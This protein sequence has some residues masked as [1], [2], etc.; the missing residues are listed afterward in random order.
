MAGP[1]PVRFGIL[2]TANI[3]GRLVAA[4]ANS[5]AAELVAVSSRDADTLAAYCQ[6]HQLADTVHRH[7]SYE[8]LLADE[9][10]E[11]IYNPL[12]NSL[13]AEWTIR[14]AAAGKHI[15]CEK[16]LA[17]DVSECQAMLAAADQ[18]GVRFMEAFMY[19]YHP[20]TQRVRELVADGAIGEVRLIRSSFCFTIADPANIRVRRD[21]AGGATMDV[22]CY[23][24][25]F[26]RLI[27][28]AE[29][30]R[31]WATATFGEAPEHDVDLTLC[32]QLDFAGGAVS[33]FVC[34]VASDGCR[35]AFILGSTGSIAIDSPWHPDP[36]EA[37]LVVKGQE[38]IIENG[39]DAYQNELEV[40]CRSLRQGTPL[41][42]P[43]V[44]GARNMAALTAVLHSA[45]TGQ[46][47]V[48]PTV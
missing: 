39:G 40:F 1:A 8:S 37:R 22:G 15:L 11:A 29:P 2:S 16:P 43:A 25:N 20:A 35:G 17:R 13:H 33:Q 3:S 42:L 41:P 32:G 27:T 18:A 46:P 34:S 30:R 14:A 19:R 36:R 4:L 21:V 9:T 26:S 31:A 5:P 23:C 48:V 12:P 24:I 10:V 28:G 38:Y 7:T 45:R 44:D 47:V 6:K